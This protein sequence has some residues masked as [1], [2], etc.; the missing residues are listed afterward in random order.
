MA[1]LR[2]EG[3]NEEIDELRRRLVEA[4][5]TL[6]AIRSGGVDAFL[7]EEAGGHKVYTLEG[8]DRPYRILVEQMHQGAAMLTAAGDIAYCNQRLAELLGVKHFKLVGQEFSEF[9]PPS[10]RPRYDELLPKTL[11]EAGQCETLLQHVDGRKIPVLLTFNALDS[12]SGLAVGVL[13]TDLTQQ[14]YQERLNAALDSSRAN[15]ER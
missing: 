15:E 12:A 6:H 13:V 7:V 10:E 8:A 4:E 5:E 2:T 14:R 9:L 1:E 11:P 3:G